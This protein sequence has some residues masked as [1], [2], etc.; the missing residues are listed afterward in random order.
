MSNDG[1]L[2]IVEVPDESGRVKYR[3]SRALNADRTKWIRHGRFVAYH[4]GGAVQSEGDY[5]DDLEEGL[6]RDYY[7]NGV[8]AAEG[9][10]HLGKEHGR[11]RFWR[12]DGVLEE[13]VEYREGQEM[14]SSPGPWT[15]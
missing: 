8:V 14:L 10:Y 5:Q 15:L 2:T 1:V 7:A 12:E 4:P 9:T 13:V 6:W 11:W 3:Y